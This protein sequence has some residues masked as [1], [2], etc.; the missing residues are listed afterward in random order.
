[1]P[2]DNCFATFMGYYCP[3]LG[4]N[5]FARKLKYDVEDGFYNDIKVYDYYWKIIYDIRN[6]FELNEEKINTINKNININID[7]DI[8]KLKNKDINNGIVYKK[9]GIVENGNQIYSSDENSILTDESDAD[10]RLLE[11]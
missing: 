7:L 10:R 8:K 11:E 3:G 4:N 6:F 1:M 5:H 2:E 9:R